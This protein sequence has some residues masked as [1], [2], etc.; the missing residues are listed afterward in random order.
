MNDIVG[1]PA[2][3]RFRAVIFD[4]GGVVCESPLPAIAAYETE[5][6]LS[7]RFIAGLVIAGGDHGPWSRL[8]RGELDAAAFSIAF[9][10]E[11]RA[12][13]QELDV[14]ALL[15]R[16]A[17]AALV[18]QTMLRALRRLRAAGLRVA[19][20][21]NS[22]SMPIHDARVDALRPEFDCFVES[23][24]VGMRKPER[25]IYELVCRTLTVQPAAAIFLDDLGGNLKPARAM[26]MTTIKVGEPA[27]AIAEL[28]R[29]TGVPLSR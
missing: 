27:L 4:L 10:T 9:S 12:G 18:R 19:A 25:R 17:E 8:E 26:G 5:T 23:H 13:G 24:R 11:A 14:T 21:T 2:P 29:L 20:L 15:G 22:W 7:A 3:T 1:T 16:I 28:E 6:G